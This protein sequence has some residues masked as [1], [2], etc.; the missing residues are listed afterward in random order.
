MNAIGYIRLSVRDQS[1]YSLEYQEESI[2]DYCKKNGITLSALF[3]DNGESSYTFDRPDYKAVEAFIKKHKGQNQYFI[4]MDHD[5]F[6]R[7]ISEA[8]SKITELEVKFGIKVVATTEPLDIDPSDPNVFM[9]VL[10]VT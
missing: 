2:R 7:N 4:I 10:S 3:K 9:R 8:L 1:R 6:S 5:R